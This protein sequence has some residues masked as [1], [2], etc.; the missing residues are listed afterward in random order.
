MSDENVVHTHLMRLLP[1]PISNCTSNIQLPIHS[2][3]IAN[4]D[5]EPAIIA[6]KERS[7]VDSFEDAITIM[8]TREGNMV[9]VNLIL[10]DAW[11]NSNPF[12]LLLRSF[13]LSGTQVVTNCDDDPV[14]LYGYRRSRTLELEKSIEQLS[15]PL[16]TV[17]VQNIAEF[18]YAV[19]SFEASNENWQANVASLV[20][21]APLIIINY[22]KSA[23]GID[24]EIDQIRRF[25]KQN[26]TAVIVEELEDH[27]PEDF[28]NVFFIALDEEVVS[29]PEEARK[30]IQAYSASALRSTFQ[31]APPLSNRFWINGAIRCDIVSRCDQFHTHGLRVYLESAR[32]TCAILESL[33]HFGTSLGYAVILQDKNRIFRESYW[34]AFLLMHFTSHW[35]QELAARY[36]DL[37]RHGIA[38]IGSFKQKFMQLRSLCLCMLKCHVVSDAF[39]IDYNTSD[40]QLGGDI[41]LAEKYVF[42]AIEYYRNRAIGHSEATDIARDEAVLAYAAM[43]EEGEPA[44]FGD[45]KYIAMIASGIELYSW[46]DAHVIASLRTRTATPFLNAGLRKSLEDAVLS[47]NWNDVYGLDLSP[48]LF[49]EIGRLHTALGAIG[50]A[51]EKLPDYTDQLSRIMTRRIRVKE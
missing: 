29:L 23:P 19:P 25:E 13:E 51:S 3:P 21:A 5:F 42:S 38:L 17:R 44:L 33:D 36:L 24:Y 43:R 4:I 27:P 32:S 11:H 7:R 18:E 2:Q 14:S 6:D 16:R 20:A 30:F 39:C 8:R 1:W 41:S 46:T 45:A 37:E 34:M 9:Q 35:N 26:A 47:G 10:D 49:V 48:G 12:V 15:K 31:S 28:P 50:T 22:K 40:T